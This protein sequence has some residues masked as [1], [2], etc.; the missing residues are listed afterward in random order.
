MDITKN[1]FCVN[2]TPDALEDLKGF[3]IRSGLEEFVDLLVDGLAFLE[4]G[5]FTLLCLRRGFS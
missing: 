4:L 2:T 1:G 5:I 3:Y